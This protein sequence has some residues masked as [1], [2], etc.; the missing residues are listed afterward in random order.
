MD[1]QEVRRRMAD[2]WAAVMHY[3][4]GPHKVKRMMSGRVRDGVR[5]LGYVP[6]LRR[7]W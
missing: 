5:K 6:S 1:E 3:P 4:P 7:R 2:W